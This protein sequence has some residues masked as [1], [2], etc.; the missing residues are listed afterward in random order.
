MTKLTKL[1][2]IGTSSLLLNACGGGSASTSIENTTGTTSGTELTVGAKITK[3]ENI[4]QEL[5]TQALSVIN[6]N[7]SGTA[8]YLDTEALNIN[9]ALED[10]SLN[11][12]NTAETLATLIDNSGSML[13]NNTSSTQDDL[14]DNKSLKIKCDTTTR[15]CTYSYTK[16]DVSMYSGTIVLPDI[17]D[18]TNPGNFTSVQGQFNGTIPVFNDDSTYGTAQMFDLDLTVTKTEAGANIEV[19]NVSLAENTALVGI[20]AMSITAVYDYDS[21][22]DD[23]TSGYIK[24]N[25]VTFNGQC[26]NYSAIGTLKTTDYVENETL[27]QGENKNLLPSKLSFNGSLT[28]TSTKG[29]ISGLVNIDWKN[30][31]TMVENGDPEVDISVD[32]ILAMPERPEMTLGLTYNNAVATEATYHNFTASYS[33][34]A[35]V[36]DTVGMLDKEGVNGHITITTNNGVEFKIIISGEDIVEGN[37]ETGTGSIVTVDGTIIGTLEYRS[38]IVVVKYI[39]GSFESIP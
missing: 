1:I 11:T 8:G 27:L 20:S 15:T 29:K 21:T 19:S 5:R 36:I 3:A 26:G 39:D 31:A 9:T 25:S 37:A 16:E 30:A 2:V 32:G 35:L 13:D 33:Y 28:N 23:I 12:E 17:N 34:D 6:Y 24:L 38:E 10:C 22:I 4:L 14:G 18:E 7:D